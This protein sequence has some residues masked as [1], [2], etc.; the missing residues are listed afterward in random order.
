MVETFV[1]L[2]LVSSCVPSVYSM[3]QKKTYP[4]DNVLSVI[5]VPLGVVFY[6]GGGIL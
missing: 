5:K 1:A 4:G 3:K 2:S 6:G